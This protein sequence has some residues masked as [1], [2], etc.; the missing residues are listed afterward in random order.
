MRK[1]L[2]VIVAA[3][4][5][6]AQTWDVHLAEEETP[7]GRIDGINATFT[8]AHAPKPWLSLKLFRNG[9]RL[10]RCQNGA[11]TMCDYTLVSPYNKLTFQS[12][13]VPQPGDILLADYRW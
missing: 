2:S 7:G 6:G 3:G 4:A 13:G 5:L 12:G 10:R 9:L 1:I 11:V 8:L